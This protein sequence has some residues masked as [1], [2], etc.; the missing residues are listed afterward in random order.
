M[1]KSFTVRYIMLTPCKEFS[2]FIEYQHLC[3][4][5]DQSV[6]MNGQRTR[7]LCHK[8]SIVIRIAKVCAGYYFQILIDRL[9]GR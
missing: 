7:G 1:A 8:V 9:A 2:T 3:F 6:R 4:K 5:Q